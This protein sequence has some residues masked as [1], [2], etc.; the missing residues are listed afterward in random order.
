VFTVHD[1]ELSCEKLIRVLV[2]T[3]AVIIRFWERRADYQTGVQA[4]SK[5]TLDT[6]QSLKAVLPFAFCDCGHH[7]KI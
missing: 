6:R 5:Q 1:I 4:I 2:D 7:R 3:A